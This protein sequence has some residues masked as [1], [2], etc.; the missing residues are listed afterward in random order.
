MQRTWIAIAAL[1]IAA[2]GCGSGGT[3]NGEAMQ[4][5]LEAAQDDARKAETER[6]QLAEQVADLQ[7]QLDELSADTASTPD[8]GPQDADTTEPETTEP[9]AT[10]PTTTT[11]TA[12]PTGDPA[13]PDASPY[14]VAFGDISVASLPAGDPGV[15]AVVA[16]TASLDD[17]RSLPVVVRNNTANPIGQIEVTGIARDSA[18]TLVGSGSSQGF[19]PVLVEPGEIAWGYVYFGDII[20]EGLTFELSTNGE[21]P[22]YFMPVEITEL[23]AI[24]DQIIGAL[25]NTSDSEVSGPIGIGGACFAIDGT[26]VGTFSPYAEQDDLAPGG[27][28][29]FSTDLYGDPCPI[30]LAGASGYGDL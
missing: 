20:G 22:G 6:D 10:L 30:G 16:A 17:S 28:G 24:G 9:E 2:A 18:G 3:D 5:E 23:N 1:T 14:A 7:G 29:S 27:F 12:A 4:N 19:E 8:S 15:V 25:A 26:L 21:E 11:T 13:A